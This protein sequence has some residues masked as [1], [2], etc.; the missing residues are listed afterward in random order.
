[1]QSLTILGGGPAGLGTA[2][3]AHREGLPFLLFEKSQRVGGLCRT[4]K[5]GEH[6]YDCGAHRLHDRDTDITND[7]RAMLGDDLIAV[8][9][10]SKIYD[11]GRF[12]DFP[13]TP[14]NVLFS[15]FN[16]WETGRIGVELIRSRRRSAPAV[17]F[18]DFAVSQ[19]G[20]TLARRLLLNY[21]EKLW[22]LPADQLSPDVA[23]RRLQGMTLTSL[24][25]EVLFPKKKTTH[26]DGSFLYP[27]EGYG[28]IVE[29]LEAAI[30]RES[31]RT[32][33]DIVRLECDRNR[34]RRIHFADQ[35]HVDPESRIVS[36]LPLTMTVKFLGDHVSDEV[37]E[38]V[39]GL[40]F[41]HIRLFFL[42]L[43]QPR[44]SDNA[45]IYI[46]DP[47]MCVTR[48]YEPKNRSP[49]MAP[50]DETSLVVEV[51]CFTDDPIYATSTEDLATRVIAELDSIG[52]I[53][54]S[55]VLEWRHHFL[56]NAYP[57]YSLN[58]AARVSQIVD[59]LSA[60][61][62]LDLIGR[63]G[64]FFYSHLHDQLRFGKDY[65]AGL[66]E[67]DAHRQD[68]ALLDSVANG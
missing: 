47:K 8:N 14:L 16:L 58:Y 53:K 27:R 19:F 2:F 67:S 23:T 13:P 37:R 17:S 4:L 51:P 7:L 35:H 21:S 50:P 24:F 30:P 52:I 25:L 64:Q 22:G 41:R 9:A 15:G 28:H 68:T 54:A 32:G 11:R 33:H 63:G 10:P 31:V 20:E 56:P 45:S 59:A 40:R 49:K 36:T 1:V 60:I 29:T 43:A 34:I 42:R 55:K 48:M 44:V 62:N 26:I 65:V 66:R 6:S 39:A 38:A 3:Y 46:P 18:A 57:V 12:I 61:S 5:H